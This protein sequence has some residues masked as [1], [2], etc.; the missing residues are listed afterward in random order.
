MLDTMVETLPTLGQLA[1]MSEYIE[2]PQDYIV[3]ILTARRVEK[4]FAELWLRYIKARSISGEVSTVVATYRRIYEYFT[5]SDDLT[6]LVTSLMEGGG[7]TSEEMKI[8]NIDLEL[9]KYYRIMSVLVPTLRQFIADALYLPE[10]DALL[11]DLLRAR[12]VDVEKYKQQVEYYRKL[13]R[14]RM[15]W[16]QIAW[17]RTQLA[18][19]YERGVIDQAT[20][21]KKLEVLKN[22]GLSDDE[23]N[24]LLDGMELR[25]AARLASRR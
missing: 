13:V 25:R 8:F 16:R 9:R 20:L 10:R 24:I 23:I 6:K 7:W 1:V 2:V 15:A 3:S 18:Y 12:G 14:N 4:R 22:Y 17:Y 19:A 11:N 5:V 21:R